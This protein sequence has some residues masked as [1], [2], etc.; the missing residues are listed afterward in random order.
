VFIK[1][2]AVW[3]LAGI[4]LAVD[5][6]YNTTNSGPGFDAAIFDERGLYTTNSLAGG[7]DPVLSIGPAPGSFYSTRI[8][9]HVPWINS[10]INGPAQADAP[11]LQTSAIAD[12]QYEDEINSM[13]DAVAKKITVALPAGSRFYRLR[14]CEPFT[15]Q[16]IQIQ[17]GNLV[18]TYQ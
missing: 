11:V 16:S 2:G 7:W 3:K 14:A 1:D 10:V 18:L 15:I 17:N 12:R 8:A 6:P 9:A 4:N 5:G 13:V